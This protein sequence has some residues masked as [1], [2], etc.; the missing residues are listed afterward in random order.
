MEYG[1]EKFVIVA[2]A[3]LVATVGGCSA[4]QNSV[5]ESMVKAG[6]NPQEAYCAIKGSSTDSTCILIASKK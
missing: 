5:I 1:V 2:F 6:A 3:V 4:H